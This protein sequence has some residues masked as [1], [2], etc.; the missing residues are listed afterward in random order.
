LNTNVDFLDREYNPRT[1]I[2]QFADFFARWKAQAGQTRASLHAR[3]DLAYGP[4]ASE[5]LD[6]FPA[7]APNSP[8]LVFIHGGYWRA[9]DKADFS[10]VAP[11]YVAAGIS[12]AIPNYGLVPSTPVG[13]I[14]RQMR[15]ACAWAFENA[16][17]IG[18]DKRRI[19]CAGHSAGGHLTAMM[20][21]TDWPRLSPRLPKRLLA[22]ALSISGLF[23]LVPLTHAPFLSK[24]LGLD[25]QAA[26]ALSPAALEQH[27]PA[28]L[29]RAVG[30]LESGEFHR[31]SAIIA[32][33]WPG[34]C[35]GALI[36]VP[37]CNHLSVC[38][39]LAEPGTVL[40]DAAR[41]AIGK[42]RAP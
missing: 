34:A 19:F 32:D 4:S 10:W 26:C 6:L 13:E 33:H 18:V 2:P 16:G 8:L 31:Q 22:G 7:S 41:D 15:R 28:P 42:L 38:D 37:G 3:L 24:D 29:L 36:D 12:V 30:A 40:F 25:E 17:S 5:T 11:A 9:L 1:Q 39:A 27:D 35:T 14:V 23:D 21:A 20:L